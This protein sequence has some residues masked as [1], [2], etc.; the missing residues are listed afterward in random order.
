MYEYRGWVRSIYDADTLR[1]DVD[2][3][4]GVHKMSEPFRLFGI[5]APEIKAPGGV[6]ARDWLRALLPLGTEV[7]LLTSKDKKEKYGRYLATIYKG[8]LNVND[9]VLAAGHAVVYLP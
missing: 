9:A 3:G 8:E 6:Q 4:F 7:I 5:N 2:L 1:I